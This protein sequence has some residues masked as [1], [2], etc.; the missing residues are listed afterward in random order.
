[1]PPRTAGNQEWVESLKDYE[2]KARVFVRLER[3]R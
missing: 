3:V 1:M 2:A